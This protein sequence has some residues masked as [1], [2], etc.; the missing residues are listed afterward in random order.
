MERIG[1]SVY[2]TKVDETIVLECNKM[3]RY[4]SNYNGNGKSLRLIRQYVFELLLVNL[5]T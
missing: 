3:R 4:Y 5:I 2:V 1:C